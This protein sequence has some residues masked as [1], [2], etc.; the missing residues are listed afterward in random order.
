MKR[1]LRIGTIAIVTA[2]GCAEPTVTDPT[3]RPRGGEC[4]T[5]TTDAAVCS[6]HSEKTETDGVRSKHRHL[7]G[8]TGARSPL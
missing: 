3:D 1:P 4:E 8:H 6:A 5:T 7:R 2:L